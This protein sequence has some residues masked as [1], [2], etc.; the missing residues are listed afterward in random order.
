MTAKPLVSE[1]N[2]RLETKPTDIDIGTQRPSLNAKVSI[3][4]DMNNL[5]ANMSIT[6][7]F[8]KIPSVTEIMS[9]ANAIAAKLTVENPQ[10]EETV[11]R[12]L[13]IMQKSPPSTT[14][15]T[16]VITKEANELSSDHNVEIGKDTARQVM[17]QDTSQVETP[18]PIRR[19]SRS[20]LDSNEVESLSQ[21]FTDGFGVRRSSRIK[22]GS[23]DLDGDKAQTSG[24][25]SSLTK[26]A[27]HHVLFHKGTK[28]KSKQ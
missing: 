14:V 3:N 24:A 27:D 23:T 9:D 28:R 26:H 13:D 11:S 25:G 2:V 21:Y 18:Q 6:P 7:A 1:S 17:P 12:I 8:V 19:S 22:P 10:V 16:A 15:A 4:T 20:H 5:S